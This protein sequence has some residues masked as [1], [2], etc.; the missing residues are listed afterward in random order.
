MRA[1]GYCRVS[2]GRQAEEGESLGVQERRVRGYAMQLGLNLDGVFV[3][4]G[5]SGSKPLAERPEG[6][7]LLAVL[8]PGDAVVTPKLDRMFR[9]ALDALDV[10][11]SLRDRGIALHMLDLGGDVTGNGIARLVFTILAAVAEAER[12]KVRERVTD[13]KRDQRARGRYLG[14]A[15][16]FGFTVSPAGDLIEDPAQQVAIRDAR[17]LRAEGASLRAVSNRLKAAG[18]D[19]SHAA[20][21]RVLREAS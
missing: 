10:M 9:S 18:H 3:E 21:A 2:T 20:W 16:P 19:L 12:D 7:K 4:R 1:Y 17:L 5:V 14:G 11:G 8:Q 15:V 6:S 13:I